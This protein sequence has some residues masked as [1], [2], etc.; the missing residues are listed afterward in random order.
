MA[1]AGKLVISDS[2]LVDYDK[3]DKDE[4]VL[5]VIRCTGRKYNHVQS[6]YGQEADML[7]TKLTNVNSLISMVNTNSVEMK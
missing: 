3:S 2:F 5:T 1:G 4:S 7:Y 6:I